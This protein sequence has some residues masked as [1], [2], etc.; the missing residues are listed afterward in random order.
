MPFGFLR[1]DGSDRLDRIEATLQRM[2]ADDRHAFD[3][4][5]STLLG[6]AAPHSV[7]A[8]LR[9]TDHHVNEAEREI[10]RE[11]VV[12]ASVHGGIDTPAI[13]IYMSIVK[14]VE[15]IGDY[16][17][18]LFDLA[19]DGARLD[20][21]SDAEALTEMQFE[22]S[23]LISEAGDVFAARDAE[24][25]RDVLM[26]GDRLLDD[27][28]HRVSE[29]VKGEDQGPTAVARALAYR[30][31]KRIVAHLMNVLSAVVV[32]IDRLDYFDEDPEDRT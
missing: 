2:F 15:R 19:A 11:L 30:Y 9:A 10:R 27:C 20:R 4:A 29:L 25:A 14:D 13:L 26:R 31:L 7:G 22:V 32:P 6:G 12:H 18:N 23:R 5:M 8:E 28:D 21:A 3:L 24:R 16:A 17:K 1:D